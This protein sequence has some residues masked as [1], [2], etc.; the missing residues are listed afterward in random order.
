MRGAFRLIAVVFLLA[1]FSFGLMGCAG[2][3]GSA[4][5]TTNQG[6]RVDTPD[7]R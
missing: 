7:A 4:G 6:P 2:M 5:L 1:A 3:T